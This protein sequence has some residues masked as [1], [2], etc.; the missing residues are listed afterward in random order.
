LETFSLIRA[1]NSDVSK[2]VLIGGGYCYEGSSWLKRK[3]TP[4]V[5][6]KL[7][8]GTWCKPLS[9]YFL[10]CFLSWSHLLSLLIKEILGQMFV[11]RSLLASLS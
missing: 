10:H 9:L 6:H 3:A 2:V 8:L 4:C 5:M 7:K 11:Y 1:A